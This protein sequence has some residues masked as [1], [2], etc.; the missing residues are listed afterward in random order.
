M[1]IVIRA[2]VMFALLFGLL[3]LMGKRELGQMTPFELVM[4][5]VLGDLIQQGI[6]HNDFSLTGATLAIATFAFWATVLGWVSYRWP[7][8]ERAIEG[9]PRVLIRDGAWIEANMKRDRLTRRELESEMRLAGI[10]CVR[11]VAWAILEPEGR[12]SFIKRGDG[13]PAKAEDAR[14]A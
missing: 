1:D 10:A 4:L 12:I 7:R 11:D 9:E 2:S 6:T 5:V 3:R 14:P 13:E 8:A